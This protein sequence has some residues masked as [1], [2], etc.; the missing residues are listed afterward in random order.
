MRDEGRSV[1]A[2]FAHPQLG[3][4]PIADDDPELLAFV[5]GGQSE[6][7]MCAYL[8]NSD[9]DLL[10]IV[11]ELINVLINQD[12]VLLTDFPEG[13]QRKLMRRQAIRSK[14]QSFLPCPPAGSQSG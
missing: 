2:V 4:D 1:V 12:L 3:A 7:V 6:S 11:E 8:A 9:A 14:L 10:R 13:A 5:T